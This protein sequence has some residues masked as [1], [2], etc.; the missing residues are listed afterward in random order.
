MADPTSPEPQKVGPTQVIF[1]PYPSLV[2]TDP[3]SV[4]TLSL[5]Q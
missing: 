1:D 2:T 3:K 4:G 5:A